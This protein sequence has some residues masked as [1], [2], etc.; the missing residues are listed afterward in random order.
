MLEPF[1]P[2][3]PL[4]RSLNR[5]PFILQIL[6]GMILGVIIAMIYPNDHAILPMLGNLFVKGLKSVAPFLVFVLVSAAIARHQ[7]GVQSNIKPII[8]LYVVSMLCASSLALFMSYTFPS[9][10]TELKAA[11]ANLTPPKGIS[12]VISN[13]VNQAIDNPFT[14]LI[15]GNYICILIWAIALGW[16]FRAAGETTRRVLEDLAES[17]SSVVRMVIRF[18]PLGVM[19]LVYNSCTQP[20]GFGNLLNYVHVVV[21]LVSTMLI[22]AFGLNAVIVGLVTRS[23]PFP[24]ILTC[25]ARSGLTAFFTRSSAANLPVNL[26]LCES[27][28]LPKSTY[29]ISIPL[30]CTINMSGAGVTIVVMTMAAVNTL[31]IHVDIWSTLLMCI[32]SVL[33]ACGASGV[34][35][36]SLMLIPLA[37]SIFGI[38]ND[39]AMQIVG[40]GF[41]I[42]VVQDS[43]ETAL[44]SSTDVLFT[45]AACY[46]ADRIARAKGQKTQRELE[47]EANVAMPSAAAEA[48]AA[49]A[50]AARPI[51]DPDTK[52]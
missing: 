25:C 27:L 45:A 7:T 5:I 43:T 14:A 40:I 41:I 24:L 38:S 19:G 12:E 39:I 9:V 10:F 2:K 49:A 34:A 42:G 33:C 21:V 4:A 17:V 51:D 32:V 37:C 15:Q 31:G 18:A 44:N 36:G 46:R 26:Q 20:G 16:T 22:I 48:R 11:D 35:G 8:V 23:N 52:D 3:F 50:S 47:D 28:K 6:A 13:F 29:S 30:G 1:K